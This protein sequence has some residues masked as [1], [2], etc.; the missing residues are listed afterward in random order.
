MSIPILELIRVEQSYEYGTFGILKIQ[1]QLF[2][3]TLEPSDRL[4][5]PEASCIPVSQYIC[6]RT[7]SPT[8]HIETFQ[9]MD[10]PERSHILF[11]AGNIV[12]NT[13]GCIILAQHIGKL[14]GERAVLNS[15]NTFRRFMQILKDYNTLHLT[16]RVCY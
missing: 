1:K 8:L 2:C 12:E 9:V 5:A 15:G 3:N 7:N 16:I 11:H 13:K 4:N 6:K 10:V 14:K